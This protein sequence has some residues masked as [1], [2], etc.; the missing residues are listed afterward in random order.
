MSD[1]VEAEGL[2]DQNGLGA[3]GG[4]RRSEREQIKTLF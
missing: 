1:G 4:N 2:E 3:V